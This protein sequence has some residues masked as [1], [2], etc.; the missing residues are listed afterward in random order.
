M[1]ALQRE[2]KKAYRI[3]TFGNDCLE[4]PKLFFGNEMDFSFMSESPVVLGREQSE[5]ITNWGEHDVGF[6]AVT[7]RKEQSSATT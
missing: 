4:T 5:T 2:S 3:K 1:K 7:V 6:S